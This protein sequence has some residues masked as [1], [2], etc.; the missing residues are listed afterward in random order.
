[1]ITVW[2]TG[3]NDS[4]QVVGYAYTAGNAAQRAF[5]RTGTA[6]MVNLGTL[7]G[8]YSEALP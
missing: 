2:G 7:G 5:V 4:G 3:I 1:M 6:P 8:T